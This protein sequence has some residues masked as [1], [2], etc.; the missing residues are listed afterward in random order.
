MTVE[1]ARHKYGTLANAKY[2]K[3]AS[4]LPAGMFLVNEKPM[5]VMD[6]QATASRFC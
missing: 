4:S 5:K 6:Y 3:R 1:T 2:L